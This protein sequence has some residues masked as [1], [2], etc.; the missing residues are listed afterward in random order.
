MSLLMR[1]PE[2]C[3]S[4]E[5][6]LDDYAE[7]GL[8][9]AVM[10]AARMSSVLRK[11]GLL[12]P[13]RLE[14]H[15]FVSGRG[16]T[17][18]SSKLALTGNFNE[19]EVKQ[20]IRDVRPVAI[21]DAEPGQLIISGPGTWVDVEGTERREPNLVELGVYPDEFDLA[22]QVSV[23]HD[24]WSYC[25]FRG[26]PHP[27]LQKRNAPR[28]AAALQEL[29]TLLGRPGTPGE[30]TYFGHAEGRGLEMP[31]LIDGLGPDLTDRF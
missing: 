30:P 3:A 6:E 25:D 29:D 7:P 18:A 21:P 12:E 16:G 22:A 14:W 1:A 17:G 31:D 19:V 27:D 8:D 9:S 23:F 10:I 24:I 5:W 26:V 15:W 2:Q 20:R 11:H 28:L 13:T 4:W